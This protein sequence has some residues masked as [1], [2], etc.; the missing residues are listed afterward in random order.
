MNSPIWGWE[1]IIKGS[2]FRISYLTLYLKAKLFYTF[3]N[4]ADLDQVALKR[5]A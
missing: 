2:Q 3:A 5:A 1:I 4:R